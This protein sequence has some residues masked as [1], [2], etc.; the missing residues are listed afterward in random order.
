MPVHDGRPAVQSEPPARHKLCHTFFGNTQC[1]CN[2]KF[3]SAMSIEA[4][5]LI[6]EI[7]GVGDDYV[8][9]F[10]NSALEIAKN[11]PRLGR[12]LSAALIALKSSALR[13]MSASTRSV[14]A[15]IVSP[16]L[17]HL[18]RCQPRHRQAVELCAT[19]C[20]QARCARSVRS[21]T[22]RALKRR[23]SL[24]WLE[25]LNARIGYFRRSQS[26]LW[27]CTRLSDLDGVGLFQKLHK[28]IFDLVWLKWPAPSKYGFEGSRPLLHDEGHDRGWR[29]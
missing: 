4:L 11:C 22:C 7:G 29:E 23:S 6:N 8:G 19:L 18:R 28:T 16:R 10:L 25:K 24:R 13:F 5:I 9:R 2:A 21:G 14:L 3:A 27:I 20:Q 26:E 12:S 1:Q 15:A 17:C